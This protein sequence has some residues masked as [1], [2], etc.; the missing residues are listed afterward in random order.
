MPETQLIFEQLQLPSGH[1]LHARAQ[2]GVVALVAPS[3]RVADE[4][5]L[6]VAGVHPPQAGKVL[7]DGIAPFAS[8][9]TRSRV[10]TVLAWEP[11][12]S[13]QAPELSPQSRTSAWITCTLGSQPWPA[14]PAPWLSSVLAEWSERP[15]KSLPLQVRRALLLA[16]ALA[17]PELR[18]L[19]L[20]EPW[21]CL[22]TDSE[23]APESWLLQELAKPALR[24]RIVLL[25]GCSHFA[26]QFY[27]SHTLRLR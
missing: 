3:P 20:F 13:H 8:P 17:R 7:L 4:A 10:A 15:L 22:G 12:L 14:A 21:T 6:T 27:T 16:A 19:Q 2:P 9:A 1:R 24:E 26:T 25:S 11:C 18:V 23:S 5:A